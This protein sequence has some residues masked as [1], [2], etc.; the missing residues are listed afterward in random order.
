MVEALEDSHHGWGDR[1][2]FHPIKEHRLD[3]GSMEHPFGAE[4]GAVFI[5]DSC[6]HAPALSRLLDVM[7]K[8]WPVT[9]LL[10]DD[11]SKALEGSHLL[12]LLALDVKVDCGCLLASLCSL[13]AANPLRSCRT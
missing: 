8:G 13:P 9:I 3:D 4:C 7:K 12:D 5:Q 11:S 6:Q 2:G 10:V 1:P